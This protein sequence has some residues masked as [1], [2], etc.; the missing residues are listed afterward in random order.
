[1]QPLFNQLSKNTRSGLIQLYDKQVMVLV[2]AKN[3]DFLG[4][5]PTNSPQ[6]LD[7]LSQLH[8]QQQQQQQ[9][10]MQQGQVNQANQM[11]NTQPQQQ[12]QPQQKQ[13]QQQQPPMNTQMNRN[14][15]IVILFY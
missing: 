14:A 12:Q 1:M 8:A 5:M 6:F 11:R 4:L 2:Y 13:Q 9:Q 15:Q 10:S 7:T 3:R